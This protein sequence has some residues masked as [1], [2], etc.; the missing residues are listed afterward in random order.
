MSQLGSGSLNEFS[1]RARRQSGRRLYGFGVGEATVAG[2]I[3]VDEFRKARTG[4]PWGR[5]SLDRPA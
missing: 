2:V 3:E 5:G 1:R 4:A